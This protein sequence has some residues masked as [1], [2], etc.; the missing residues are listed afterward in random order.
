VVRDALDGSPT[1][2]VLAPGAYASQLIVSNTSVIEVA[3]GTIT[4]RI[5]V[6]SPATLEMSAGSIFEVSGA[7]GRINLSG[8]N[9][10]YLD[11]THGITTVTGGTVSERFQ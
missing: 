8:G 7:T 1:T 2:L 9:I 5:F 11:T 3:G 6:N 10:D 4:G